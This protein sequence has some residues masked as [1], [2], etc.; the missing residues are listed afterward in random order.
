MADDRLILNGRYRLLRA[1][2]SGGT[3]N[4]YLAEETATGQKVALKVLK[5]HIATPDMVQRF[6]REAKLLSTLRHPNVVR[7]IALEKASEGLIL[8]L[9]WVDGVR[10]D[11]LLQ[12]APLKTS[13]AMKLLQ[14][15][16]GALEAV[17]RAGIV[18]RDLKP[19]NV[20]V[21]EGDVVRLLD[22][23]IARFTDGF[24]GGNA[25]VS[26]I[27][28]AAGTPAYL[29]PEQAMARPADARADVYAFGVMAYQLLAGELPFKGSNDY[30][31][32]TQHMEKKPPRLKPLDG[33]LKDSQLIEV[34]MQCL[35][36]KPEARPR[37]GF[38]L[39]KLLE[40][41]ANA[42]PASRKWWSL[43]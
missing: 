16:A 24:L 17:H 38:A 14:Q 11:Q 28:K 31:F 5:K 19:E 26:A 20:M 13:R 33:G 12:G 40:L 15:L 35:E 18:H 1:A 36:K 43:S 27:G 6:D 39:V 25:F 32:I 2:G 9:E 37:D 22:F 30:D 29:S 4:V 34:V 3:A 41:A 10:L 21:A 8:L 23:G 42:A 7:L